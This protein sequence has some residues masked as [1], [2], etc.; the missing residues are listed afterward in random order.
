M[1]TITLP[2]TSCMLTSTTAGPVTVSA[3][4]AGDVNN[5]PSADS[6]PYQIDPASSTTT[7]VSITPPGGS[8]IGQPYTVEVSVSG[9]GTP[10]G[11]V[12]VDDGAGAMCTITLP[13]TSCVL[14][15]T[16]VGQTAISANYSGDNNNLPSSASQG[17][18]IS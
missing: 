16:A 14:T 1:C 12:T 11:T 7:I 18:V 17:Y 15:S 4:Y 9:F 3:A 5:L 8:M 2:A 13:A 10:T 6:A